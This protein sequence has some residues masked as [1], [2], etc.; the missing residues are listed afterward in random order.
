VSGPAY[1]VARIVAPA[2]AQY[3]QLH[4][5]SLP[6]FDPMQPPLEL[7]PNGHTIESMVDAAFWASV[8]REEGYVRRSRSRFSDRSRRFI[9]WSSNSPSRSNRAH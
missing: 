8:R 4:R 9:R 7:L 1:A 3:L 2:I 6:A 5:A